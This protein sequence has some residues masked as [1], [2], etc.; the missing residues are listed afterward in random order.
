M[1]LPHSQKYLPGCL[2]TGLPEFVEYFAQNYM[3]LPL[4]KGDVVFLSPGLFHGAGTN[5]TQIRG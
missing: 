5:Q 3:Q 4:A 2:T 1:Y